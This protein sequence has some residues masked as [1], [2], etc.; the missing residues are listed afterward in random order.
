MLAI[1]LAFWLGV[2][3]AVSPCPLAMN[4][5]AI[6]FIGRRVGAPRAMLASGLLYTL[7]RSAAYVA[8]AT[9]LVGGLLSAPGVSAAL[10]KTMPR[11]AG[12]L[13][14]LTGMLLLKLLT[15][16]AFGTRVTE[17]LGERITGWGV[18]GAGLLG[19]IFALMFCPVTAALF[20]LSLIP[21]ALSFDSALLLPSLYGLGTGLPVLVLAVLLASGTRLVARA[22]DRLIQVELLGT[23]ANGSGVSAPGVLL[24]PAPH[25][26]AALLIASLEKSPRYS[27][28]R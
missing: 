6:S 23:A 20:F 15:F 19:I 26:R 18:W 12:P 13:M 17:N 7:G 10:Q 24:Q 25:L 8:L 14:I 5:A 11:L 28:Y 22:F 9:L 4:I 1:V 27:S 16:G 3:T 2:L 21:L